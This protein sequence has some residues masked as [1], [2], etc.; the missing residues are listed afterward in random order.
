[1][2]LVI[3]FAAVLMPALAADP[4]A[5]TLYPALERAQC[6]MCHNDNGV[7][8]A[9]R[10]QFPPASASEDEINR[11]GLRLR[12][13]V[14]QANP[15][16]SLLLR[17]PTNR[18]PHTGGERIKPGSVE[19]GVLHAWVVYLAGLPEGPAQTERVYGTARKTLRR[20]TNSQYNHTVHDLLGD[21]THPADRFPNED[22]VNGYTNQ[23]EGQSVSPLLAEAYGRAAE[24]L[25]RSA[26]LGGDSHKLIPCAPSPGCRAEFIRQ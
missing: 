9:T 12:I 8:S 13:L 3:L 20:L 23:A 26:F 15:D 18:I 21:Q 22:F 16:Q 2:R 24:R 7:A 6:R 1:M 17:K 11:F 10:L 4:F 14:D 19:D 25:A 5:K